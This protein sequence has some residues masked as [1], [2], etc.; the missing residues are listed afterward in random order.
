MVLKGLQEARRLIGNNIMCQIYWISKMLCLKFTEVP[1]NIPSLNYL[2]QVCRMKY[3]KPKRKGIR[4]NA[5]DWD[6]IC[7]VYG[8]TCTG[9][10]DEE[11]EE[12]EDNEDERGETPLTF[13]WRSSFTLC[14]HH[15]PSHLWSTSRSSRRLLILNKLPVCHHSGNLKI[16]VCPAHTVVAKWWWQS[17]EVRSR[18]RQWWWRFFV[19]VPIFFLSEETGRTL[20]FPLDLS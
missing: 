17:D 16:F 5:D 6:T 20:C 7:W 10:E 15:P 12:E 18:S 19:P 3:V 11:E 9:D 8:V 1:D 4:P 14:G 2:E 13:V